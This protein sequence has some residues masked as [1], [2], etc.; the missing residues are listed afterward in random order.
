M[1]QREDRDQDKGLWALTSAPPA[2]AQVAPI[3]ILEQI[4]ERTLIPHYLL[5]HTTA[6]GR[7]SFLWLVTGQQKYFAG[8]R[9]LYQ[10]VDIKRPT[11]LFELL[12]SLKSAPENGELVGGL[13]ISCFIASAWGAKF[14]KALQSTVDRMPNLRTFT[15][16]SSTKIPESFHIPIFHPSMVNLAVLLELSSFRPCTTPLLP[17]VT[18]GSLSSLV[19][20]RLTP[21]PLADKHTDFLDLHLL[22][23]EEICIDLSKDSRDLLKTWHMPS[24]RRATLVLSRGFQEVTSFMWFLKK[25]GSLIQELQIYR[26]L[27]RNIHLDDVCPNLQHLAFYADADY[28]QMEW[29][30][31]IISHRKLKWVDMWTKFEK[32]AEYVNGFMLSKARRTCPSLRGI[33]LLDIALIH[34]L[35]LPFRLPPS[36]V[37]SLSDAYDI[38]LFGFYLRHRPWCISALNQP[39]KGVGAI[40]KEIRPQGEA[41]SDSE[42]SS[43]DGWGFDDSETSILSDN[44]GAED[45][46]DGDWEEFSLTRSDVSSGSEFSDGELEE[47]ETLEGFRADSE[48]EGGY[49]DFFSS[50]DSE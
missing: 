13:H 39:F 42:W 23:L 30:H 25:H 46:T 18:P 24:L 33:R 43:D 48:V 5:D 37:L 12:L 3:E 22:S 4:F 49:M 8:K 35:H 1:Y 28:G 7:D 27:P 45:L 14:S 41:G 16:K 9:F 19:M 50:Y 40:R 47:L 20:L 38:K 32:S 34:L 21:C 17:Q 31:T 11:Q 10:D 44:P 2:P 29:I 36:S 6:F 15:F 26:V